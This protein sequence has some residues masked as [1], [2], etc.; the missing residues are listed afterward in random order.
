MCQ[1]CGAVNPFGAVF[2]MQCGK[3]FRETTLST[4]VSK[5]IMMYVVSALV[6]PFGLGW[7]IKYARQQD[8]YAKRIGIAIIVITILSLIVNVWIIA[9]LYSDY[10]KLLNSITDTSGL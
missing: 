7:G 3:P 5:Q 9:K 2:C 1:A 6:P 8:S 10:F 4:A